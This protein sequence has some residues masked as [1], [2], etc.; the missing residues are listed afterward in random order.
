M[1]YVIVHWSR[2]G[3]NK[4]IAET[5]AKKLN[6]KSID[7]K[8]F[9]TDEANPAVMSDADLY[10]FSSPTEAFRLQRNMKMF[11]KNLTG[12]QGKKY[13]IINTHAMKRN[14]LNSMQKILSKKKMIFVAGVDFRVGKINEKDFG[15]LDGWETKLDEFIAQL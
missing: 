3:N 1:K 5:I 13:A 7:V 10:I 9:K 12:M 2:F 11:L 6:E 8:V 14:W 15:L 4:K